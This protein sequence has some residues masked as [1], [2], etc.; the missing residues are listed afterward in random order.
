MSEV[1]PMLSNDERTT[2]DHL[3]DGLGGPKLVAALTG[4][5]ADSVYRWR[6]GRRAPPE[7][8]IERLI[9]L[10]GTSDDAR[11]RRIATAVLPSWRAAAM[12]RRAVRREKLRALFFRRFGHMPDATGWYVRGR[13]K[14][15]LV[16]PG[17][18]AIPRSRDRRYDF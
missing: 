3:I 4:R 10:C 18:S 12:Q 2:W 15:A 7:W 9:T 5:C 17:Q 14:G 1:Q 8:V 6:T 13:P 11:L 16:G